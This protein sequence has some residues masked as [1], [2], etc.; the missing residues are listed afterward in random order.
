LLPL[1]H[2]PLLSSSQLSPSPNPL[3]PSPSSLL[4]PYKQLPNTPL[5]PT[6]SLAQPQ[7]TISW[8]DQLVRA[9][10]SLQQSSPSH[11]IPTHPPTT[12][13]FAGLLAVC[14]FL[15]I[16]ISLSMVAYGPLCKQGLNTIGE[17]PVI[18]RPK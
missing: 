15:P 5:H 2:L 12:Q 9:S 7:P 1:A 6:P 3:L 4:N 11:P 13:W 10:A 17:A 16:V 18:T 8:L 14:S